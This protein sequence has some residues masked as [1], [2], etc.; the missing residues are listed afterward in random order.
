[1]PHVCDGPYK[2]PEDVTS[3]ICGYTCLFMD[4]KIAPFEECG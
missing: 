3:V 2:I 1:M 4:T